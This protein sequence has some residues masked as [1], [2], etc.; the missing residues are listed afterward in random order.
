[1]KALLI[2]LTLSVAFAADDPW[3]KVKDLKSG[4]EVRILKRG[5]QKPIEGKL[6]E[7]RDDAVVVVLK[8]E[9][10]SV[11]KSDIERLDARPKAGRVTRTSDARQ[12]DPDPTPPA[13][14]GHGANVPGTNYSSGLSVGSKPDYETVYRRPAGASKA[15]PKQ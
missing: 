12:T 8:N 15:V 2:L 1:M 9:Q 5:A 11:A 13:G 4:S 6:D 10:V 7:V 14:M 3:T